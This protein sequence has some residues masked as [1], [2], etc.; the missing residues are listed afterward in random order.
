[1]KNP[2]ITEA[3][4]NV[5]RFQQD[6]LGKRIAAIEKEMQGLD[7]NGCQPIYGELAITPVQLESALLLKRLAGQINVIIHTLG[8]LLSL[9]YILEDG[10]VIEAL[11]LGAGNTG[12]PFDLETNRRVAEFKFIHWKGGPESIRKNQLFKDF[13]LLAEYD[14]LK[15]RYLYVVE[16]EIPLKTLNGGR[17]LSSV[18]SRN[19]KLLQD[20]KERYQG[21]FKTVGEYYHYRKDRVSLVDL[22]TVVPQFRNGFELG[23]EDEE[24][25][26]DL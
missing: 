24:D 15:A 7:K 14:T 10:E 11:S 17:A 18:L 13:Y 9:P 20:F 22:A 16:D 8:I 25:G 21:R 1:M 26:E 3:A 12:K 6:N 23:E 19:N 5:Q 4:L 2:S